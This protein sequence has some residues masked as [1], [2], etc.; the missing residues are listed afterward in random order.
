M[1]TRFG[2][3]GSTW[4]LVEVLIVMGSSNSWRMKRSENVLFKVSRATQRLLLTPRN[5]IPTPREF[6]PRVKA[7]SCTLHGATG[8]HPFLSR[9]HLRFLSFSLLPQR[10]YRRQSGSN[11]QPQWAIEPL[12]PALASCHPFLSLNNHY[13]SINPSQTYKSFCRFYF[14]RHFHCHPHWVGPIL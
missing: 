14:C 11:P 8:L 12:Q 6:L 3:G 10:N 7:I 13:F 4:N 2:E 9:A 1:L 5:E